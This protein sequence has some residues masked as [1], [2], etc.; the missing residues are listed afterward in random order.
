MKLIHFWEA[1]DGLAATEAEKAAVLGLKERQ[2][3]NWKR[4]LPRSLQRII[5]RPELIAALARDANETPIAS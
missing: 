3:R 5:S 2:L 1:V 4:S